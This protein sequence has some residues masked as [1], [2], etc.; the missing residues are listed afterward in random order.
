[1]ARIAVA[2]SGGVDSTVTTRLLAQEGHEVHGLFMA[3]SQPD[4]DQQVAKVKEVASRLEVELTVVDLHQVF[5]REVLDYFANSYFQGR[6]PNPCVVCNPVVK[7]GQLLAE[8]KKLG[9]Q[10]LATGHYVR[11]RESAGGYQLL[12]GVDPGKDQSYFLC[13]LQQEQLAALRFP[14]G[15]L[16][17]EEVYL[18]AEEFGFDDF[19]GQ[20][21]QDVC[22]L[23]ECSVQDF[24]GQYGDQT[25]QSG[26]IIDDHGKVLGRHQGIH[27]YTIGQRR[28]LGIPAAEPL[29]V[30][31]LDAD[32]N[33]VIV[34]GD[35]SL[36]GKEL[37]VPTMNWLAG[38]EPDLP[39]SMIVKIR[40]RHDG[41]QA[42]VSKKDDGYLIIFDEAQRAITPGQFAALYDGEVLV[43][44]GEIAESVKKM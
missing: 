37:Y 23:K 26:D 13:G 12:K 20:E 41:A 35:A 11:L 32:R 42:M 16:H 25:P 39:T 44:G 29:Y 14:L 10:A 1:M 18:L 30:I 43:G 31:D 8:A 5:K 7:C 28:G 6:T 38:V 4:L 40:Y 17:K 27:R 3:L 24:L 19:R 2:M 9:C 34:G 22:F 36:W 15:E 33:R 21:S